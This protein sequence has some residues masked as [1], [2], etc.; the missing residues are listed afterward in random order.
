[1][2]APEATPGAICF[3]ATQ[4]AS[5]ITELLDVLWERSKDATTQATAPA[6]PSQL[7][8]MYVIDRQD[9]IRMR[10][11]CHLLA[12]SPP[13]VSRMC[14]RLQA[15]G[16][17]QRLPCPES[18]RE[19]NLRLT[20][21]GKRHLRR[22]REQRETMLHHAIHHMPAAERLALAHGLTELAVQ[23]AANDGGEHSRSSAHPAA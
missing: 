7:R 21:A 20:P 19:V 22:I 1:M 13:N 23:L 2:P 17:L 9:G 15:I 10:T 4:S 3:Q 11:V 8:L 12:S 18:G 6:S 14:D 16:F 5:H